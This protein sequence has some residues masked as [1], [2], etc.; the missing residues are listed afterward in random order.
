[1]QASHFRWA[2]PRTFI[3]IYKKDEK[4]P[5]SSRAK[6]GDLVYAVILFNWILKKQDYTSFDIFNTTEGGFLTENSIFGSGLSWLGK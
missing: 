3:Q 6:R 2:H 5:K 1:L 4:K